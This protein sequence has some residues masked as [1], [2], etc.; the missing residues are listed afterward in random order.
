MPQPFELAVDLRMMTGGLCVTMA[1][2]LG[3]V[4]MRLRLNSKHTPKNDK[5]DP[6]LST[7]QTFHP[8]IGL[9]FNSRGLLAWEL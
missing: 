3:Q 2:L 4:R 8:K 6:N 5:G 1:G 7:A 9:F